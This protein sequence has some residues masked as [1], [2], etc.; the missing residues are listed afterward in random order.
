MT[1]VS[2]PSRCERNARNAM[3]ERHLPLAR[4]LALR[5]RRSP[6]EIDD[7]LQVA[8]LGL[9]KAVDRWDPDRGV[10]FT[11]FAV[12][13]ILGELRHHLRNNTWC[14]RPPRRLQDLSQ[15]IRRARRELRAATDGEPTIAELAHRLDRSRAEVT[16]AVLAS[17]GRTAS[18][19]ATPRDE[20]GAGSDAA[21]DALSE[22]DPG[23]ARVDARATIE[24]LIAVLDDRARAVL[25]LRFD[26]DL[27][28][29]Q[30]AA[31]VGCS[32]VHVS[33]ILAASLEALRTQAV[34]T[35]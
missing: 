22:L 13:T 3:I 24:R 20:D 23:Y 25:Y 8:S 9:V 15:S 29:S 34:A 32:Q 11:S 10:A 5:Y 21:V 31:A 12:P 28:Q 7:L 14:V 30:I 35:P 33:R 16:E 17:R 18:S 2:G 19:L 6:E 27:L 1:R 26:H 4:A